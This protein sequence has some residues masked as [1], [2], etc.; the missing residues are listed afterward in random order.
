MTRHPLK[1]SR[2]DMRGAGD[3]V[4]AIAQPVAEWIDSKTGSRL[5]ECQGCP[6]RRVWLNR[7]LPFR[8]G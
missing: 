5:S 7:V 1:I 6:K 4:H 3:L 8:G 2:R